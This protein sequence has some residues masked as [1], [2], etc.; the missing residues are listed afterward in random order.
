MSLINNSPV[1]DGFLTDLCKTKNELLTAARKRFLL[2]FIGAALSDVPSS[3]FKQKVLFMYG[4]NN[5]GKTQMKQLAY[6]LLGYS[7]CSI[8]STKTS[9]T[10]LKRHMA[11][12]RLSGSSDMS[13]QELKWLCKFLNAPK[14]LTSLKDKSLTSLEGENLNTPKSFDK[15]IDKILDKAEKFGKAT[16]IDNFDGFFWFNMNSL[17]DLTALTPAMREAIVLFE[18]PNVVE[19]RDASILDKMLKEK[20]AICYKASNAFSMVADSGCFHVPAM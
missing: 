3:R 17:P 11:G 15:R 4:P 6:E 12:T 8:I 1:F 18:C 9:A 13:E 20:E 14:S 10:K 16:K 7:R 5:T 2:E 19:K